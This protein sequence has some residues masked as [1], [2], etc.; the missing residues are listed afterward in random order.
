MSSPKLVFSPNFRR[1]H[2]ID[3]TALAA[4]HLK[5]GPKTA[6]LAF[7]YLDRY[8]A[9]H[10]PDEDVVFFVASVCLRL[11][12]KVEEQERLI[13]TSKSLAGLLTGLGGGVS[14]KDVFRME[15]KICSCLGYVCTVCFVDS[16]QL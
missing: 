16:C 6:H 5:L 2:L 13:P 11:A 7:S 1:R 12:S 8:N 9:V 14:P 4:A 10:R 3:W 15:L